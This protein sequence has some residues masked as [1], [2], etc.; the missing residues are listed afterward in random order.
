MNWVYGEVGTEETLQELCAIGCQAFVAPRE[1][2]WARM[3]ARGLTNHRVISTH[4]EVIGGLTLLSMAQFFGGRA[5]PMTG[6]AGVCFRPENRRQGYGLKL[7]G[8]TLRELYE[9]GVSLST[10]YPTTH[11]FYES[12]GYGLAGV[13]V[14]WSAL[15]GSFL[16]CRDDLPAARHA[17]PSDERLARLHAEFAMRQNGNLV[18][19]P[20]IRDAIFGRS[21]ASERFVTLFGEDQGYLVFSQEREGGECDLRVQDYAFLTPEAFRAFGAFFAGH[22]PIVKRILWKSSFEGAWTSLV[23]NQKE[24]KC[25][26]VSRWMLRLVHVGAALEGRGYPSG[27]SA[28]LTFELRDE[29]I[30]ENAGVWTLAVSNGAA[31]VSRGGTPTFAL[32][33][34]M[35]ASLYSGLLSVQQLHLQH[36]FRCS[37]TESEVLNALFRGQE[38][39]MPDFF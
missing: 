18:R 26:S 17:L 2:R 13:S 12:T 15:P 24:L 30:P 9:A 36:G 31:E 11:R 39:W 4:G 33:V 27:V 8:A 35:L 28:R 29:V 1:E 34:G 25:E 7:V 22:E 32:D 23:R 16:A 38:P 5:V 3:C 19:H 10:L 14:V 21:P 37:Q 20:S 6:L